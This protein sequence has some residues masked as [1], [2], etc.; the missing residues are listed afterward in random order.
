MFVLFLHQHFTLYFR[1]IW[2]QTPDTFLISTFC[3]IIGVT[4][5]SM[6]PEGPLSVNI[7]VILDNYT[8]FLLLDIISIYT[9]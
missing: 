2:S 1:L 9:L 6:M 4:F 8:P 5:I 7:A 3:G